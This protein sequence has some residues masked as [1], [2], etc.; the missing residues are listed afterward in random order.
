MTL[1]ISKPIEL[2][3]ITQAYDLA[4]VYA[5]PKLYQQIETNKVLLN[6][7]GEIV[8]EN[9]FQTSLEPLTSD[10]KKQIHFRLFLIQLKAT[11]EKQTLNIYGKRRERIVKS[12]HQL[13]VH[14]K[15]HIFNQKSRELSE[16]VLTSFNQTLWELF[17]E[18]VIFLEG[19]RFASLYKEALETLWN[20]SESLFRIFLY[21]H[22]TP[23]AYYPYLMRGYHFH[24]CVAFIRNNPFSLKDVDENY[25]LE[26]KSIAVIYKYF[27]ENLAVKLTKEEFNIYKRVS[28]ELAQLNSHFRFEIER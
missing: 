5:Q 26:P 15:Q 23:I 6:E 18:S 25:A 9:F 10:I 13:I 12:Y 24:F 14:Q 28:S 3:H 4:I 17:L 20:L 22:F 11:I 19:K 21:Q 16:D 8:E 2:E 27:T 7:Q 1:F